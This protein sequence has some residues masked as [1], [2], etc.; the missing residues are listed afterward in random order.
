LSSADTGG[1]AAAAADPTVSFATQC[2]QH[3]APHAKTLQGLATP[4]CLSSTYLLDDAA[5][6]YR[7]ATKPESATGADAD[8]FFYSRWGSPTTEMAGQLVSSLEGATAGTLVFAS[9]MNAITTLLM[10]ELKAGDHVVAPRALYGGTFE[11]FTIF[12]E[13]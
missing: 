4:I 10:A 2:A 5:H 3:R 11:W 6:S 12:G 8:G 9:G 13:R 7:L 1:A